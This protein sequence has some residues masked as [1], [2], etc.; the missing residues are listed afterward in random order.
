MP[1]YAAT[2]FFSAFLLFLV[3]PI[4]AK[5][6][7]PWFGGSAA[8][9]TT[10]L[11]FFQTALLLGYA[12]SDAIVRRL[13]PRAQVLL[14]AALLALSCATL[15]IVPGA[16]WKPSGSDD[17]SLRI[18]ALL[19]ATI[20][21]PYFLLSTTSPLIQAWFARSHPGR[22]P[23]RLFAL[24]NL[25]S[26]L[27]LL[28]YPFALE[29]WIATRVQSYGWSAAYVVFALLAA[30]SGAFAL[31]AAT[32][33][34]RVANAAIP[35]GA[36]REPAPTLGRQ[37]LWCALAATGSFLLLAVSN[38]VCQNIA[39]IPL[40]WIVPLSIY[41]LSFILCFDSSRWYRAPTFRAMLSAAI[42]VMGWTLAD[43]SLT[44]RL[45]LQIGVFCA[46][47]FLACMF[48]HGELARLKPAP[49]HL[50][51]F[52]L[53]VALGGAIGSALVGLVAPLVLPA[54]FELALGLVAC[55]AL[56]SFQVRRAH[57]V[58][59]VLAVASLLFSV[60]AAGWSVHEFY[61]NTVLARRNFYGVLRVQ[62]WEAGT[63]DYHRSLIHGTILH[64]T[65]YPGPLERQPTTYYT[66]T[67]G[68]GRV[69]ES[70]HPSLKPLKVGVI[71]LGT[72]TIAAYGAK[73]DVYRFYDINP[74]V[75]AI[76]RREF[77]YI[78][79]SDATVEI[80]LGDARLSLE[81]EP[82]QGFDVLAIDAFSS[83]AIPVHLITNEALSVY[84]RHVRPGGVIAFHV[85]N[86]YLDL[87]PVVQQLAYAQNLHAVLVADDGEEPMGSRSD[88]VLVSDSEETLG[89]PSIDAVAET[90]E[91]RP[92]WRL[93]T[94][95]FNNIV[96][97]LK[98][99]D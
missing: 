97:V 77:T 16:Q 37:I 38:H 21:L 41:L 66:A 1:L 10:C 43:S 40:L 57:P 45:Q 32:E 72:G 9:W 29:P 84:R 26:M 76:A 15:P 17:P 94:D 85:T 22:S 51:R 2:T 68:I 78:G 65:Q 88:W 35:D 58:F 5:Q 13:S 19:T 64:G 99:D 73:G 8:V 27:A 63:P 48:C 39:S 46:G 33:P 23:Y 61:E 93:W 34:R 71:G 42:G 79:K 82:P 54:Y 60:G 55:A 28:G 25:A 89:A 11:V 81:R 18:L 98:R 14:H 7:L 95:D 92:E 4:T 3:Q 67:S 75:V 31:G 90:I 6:I 30:A 91:P 74:A 12:Y 50:T 69:L 49:R 53:M 87:A 47:L 96:Q 83:D 24:S 56:L 20:G 44:H 52:Y 70:L 62:E 86:R 80:A 59:I 36:G